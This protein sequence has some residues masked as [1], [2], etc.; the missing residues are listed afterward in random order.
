MSLNKVI[1][2][3]LAVSRLYPYNPENSFESVKEI[4]SKLNNQNPDIVL[5]PLNA[6]S[7][8]LEGSFSQLSCV[9]SKSDVAIEKAKKL[10]ED[11]NSFLVLG[12]LK[13]F[14]GKPRL[15]SAVF[16]GGN[17]LGFVPNYQD[18]DEIDENTPFLIKKNTV[19][20][21]GELSFSVLCCD[22]IE[23]GFLI[24][25]VKEQTNC[26]LILLPSASPFRAD[27]VESEKELLKSFSSSLGVSICLANGGI[28]ETSAPSLF[29]GSLLLFENGVKVVDKQTVFEPAF[30]IFDLDKDIISSSQKAKSP[31]TISPSFSKATNRKQGDKLLREV[32]KSQFIP[33]KKHKREKLIIDL[34]N[35]QSASLAVR[36]KNTGLNKMVIGVSGGLDSALALLVCK[37]AGEIL[38]L[39]SDNILAVTMPAKASS[40]RTAGNAHSLISSLGC[41]FKEVPI[42][43]IC[44]KHLSDIGCDDETKDACYENAFARERTQ[45]LLD[46]ANKIGGLVVGT[47]DLSESALGFCTY[48][49]DHLA[50]Y[51]VNTSVPKSLM[52]VM[53]DFIAENCQ[54]ETLSKTLKDILATPISPELI[55]SGSEISQK[56]EEIVGP[57]EL[58]D[59][60]IFY[61]IKYK[62][63]PE[64][65]L[66]YAKTAFEGEYSEDYLRERLKDFLRRFFSSQFKRSC[67]PDSASLLTCNLNNQEFFIPSDIKNP[68][69]EF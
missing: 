25:K 50:S 10:S 1:R 57:Y 5:F 31:R 44:L 9:T 41:Q 7:S 51:N 13:I 14:A 46:L 19:F 17:L 11:L 40:E 33:S 15:L 65:I 69:T 67:S 42:E 6:L 63:S 55:G 62:M 34:F 23:R 48:G 66:L 56:T 39:A 49:G 32:S 21:V 18:Y 64:K 54:N 52:R 37:K 28:G 4:I 53:I 43:E 8:A 61:L 3:A 12:V 68:W 26:D 35:A 36:L 20:S 22:K 30:E 45:I 58:L 16:L 29:E 27:Q 2:T 60:F 38:G 24:S 59:F 47:G